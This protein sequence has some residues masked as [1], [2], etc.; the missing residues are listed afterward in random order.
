[1]LIS[2]YMW[3]EGSSVACSLYSRSSSWV[4]I[5][6]MLL[7]CDVWCLMFE[8]W[9]DWFEGQPYLNICPKSH[10]VRREWIESSLVFSSASSFLSLLTQQHGRLGNN[11]YSTC[12]DIPNINIRNILEDLIALLVLVYVWCFS[13]WGVGLLCCVGGRWSNICFSQSVKNEGVE[14][15]L[16]VAKFLTAV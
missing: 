5:S 13:K 14:S 7:T 6:S 10:S 12:N 8:I 3:R 11:P 1:M 15:G 4:L 2:W 16:S 9:I